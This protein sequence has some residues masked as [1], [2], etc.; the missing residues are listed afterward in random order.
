M[1][2]IRIGDITISKIVDKEKSPLPFNFV[3]PDGDWSVCEE[4]A[5]WLAPD[6]I[7]LERRMVLMNYHSYVVQTGRTNILIEACIGNDK[8]RGASEAFHMQS[9]DYLLRLSE[10]GI[11][12]DD[13]DI[14]MCSHMHPDHVGW[15]TQL[16]DGSWVP[17]FA[18]A[19]YVFARKEYEYWQD[20]WQENDE[21]PFLTAA[22]FDSVLPVVEAGQADFVDTD[23]E[24]EA[25]IWLEPA[26]GHSPGHIFVNIQ[27]GDDRAI[28]TGDSI[29]HVVQMAAPHWRPFFDQDKDMAMAT[30]R[31]LLDR[32]VD[33][34]TILL[35]AHFCGAS[36]GRVSSQGDAYRFDFM[37]SA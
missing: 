36:A 27:S 2:P 9:S 14:V 6:H 23:H 26:F 20:R 35:P 8:E 1:K 37:P 34:P 13:I 31:K 12:P 10:I 17:T 4:H 19:R 32:V 28:L 21:D 22:F 3:Y 24:L 11:K 18:N 33:T 25:G 15:N 7:S 30:R 5:D 16:K 29:H